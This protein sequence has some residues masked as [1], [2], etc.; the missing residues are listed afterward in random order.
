MIVCKNISLSASNVEGVQDCSCNNPL[1]PPIIF[2][3]NK[4]TSSSDFIM[5]DYS[6]TQYIIKIKI[7]CGI[8]VHPHL[9]S[10]IIYKDPHSIYVSGSNPANV[11]FVFL[12]TSGVTYTWTNLF[13][14]TYSKSL[15]GLCMIVDKDLVIKDTPKTSITTVVIQQNPSS[16]PHTQQIKTEQFFN[17]NTEINN[18][19]IYP[20]QASQYYTGTF[21]NIWTLGDAEDLGNGTYRF[22]IGLE[23]TTSGGTIMPFPYKSIQA[24][25]TLGVTTGGG[26]SPNP[27]VIYSYDN[28]DGIWYVIIPKHNATFYDGTSGNDLNL[29]LEMDL[30]LERDIDTLLINGGYS[31]LNGWLQTTTINVFGLSMNSIKWK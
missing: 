20:V 16:I 25:R 13:G 1:L 9:P 30:Y 31:I 12:P 6:P 4:A 24:I 5:W 3:D 21:S 17:I 18:I 28:N 26:Y 11:S 15:S 23:K 22:P 10:T 19:T 27:G 2:P 8:E 7:P 29:Q 14:D